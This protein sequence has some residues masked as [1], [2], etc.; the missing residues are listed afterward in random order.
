MHI[1]LWY[2][3]ACIERW[4]CLMVNQIGRSWWCPSRTLIERTPPP[5]EV[6][7]LLCSLIKNREEED[8]PWRTTPKI[9][10]FL[11]NRLIHKFIEQNCG[12]TNSFIHQNWLINKIDKQI[13]SAQ[14]HWS[15]GLVG[16]MI[17]KLIHQWFANS[18]IANSFIN[19]LQ[20]HS[21]MI[22]K[23]IHCKLIHQWFANSF[24]ND[25]QTHPFVY[26]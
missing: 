2:I 22:C 21:S 1:W 3:Y 8:S 7:Y 15:A 4:R 25:L 5:G 10:Q 20:I 26:T 17:C 11:S 23:L 6:F 18:F 12:C 19:D 13:L 16:S 14:T 24:N 9:D